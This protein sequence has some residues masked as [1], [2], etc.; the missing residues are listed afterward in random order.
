VGADDL[1]ELLAAG[2]A[3]AQPD[4]AAQEGGRELAFAVAGQYDEGEGAA[5][6]RPPGR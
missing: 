2:S 6:T 1:G 4:A 3:Q 5:A